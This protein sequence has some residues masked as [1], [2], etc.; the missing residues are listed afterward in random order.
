MGGTTPGSTSCW[1]QSPGRLPLAPGTHAPQLMHTWDPSC[2][3]LGV[4]GSAFQPLD[5]R[6]KTDTQLSEPRCLRPEPRAGP[7]LALGS[8]PQMPLE[9]GILHCGPSR[10]RTVDSASPAQ[11][12]GFPSPHAGH[13][14]RGPLSFPCSMWARCLRTRWAPG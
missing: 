14:G 10:W 3:S 2:R 12:V 6:V 11:A 4:V 8:S 9:E 7:L 13:Q 1:E 5:S